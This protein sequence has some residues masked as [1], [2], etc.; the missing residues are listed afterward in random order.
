[1]SCFHSHGQLLLD[2]AA[3]VVC[4]LIETVSMIKSPPSLILLFKLLT[5][6]INTL[7]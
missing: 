2:Q 6:V 4:S 1:M 7:S 3:S 5:L